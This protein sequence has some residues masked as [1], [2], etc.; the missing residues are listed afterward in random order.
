MEGSEITKIITGED[1]L[2]GA[3]LANDG[4]QRAPLVNAWRSD[5]PDV[6]ALLDDQSVSSRQLVQR[7][8][9]CRKRGTR[10]GHQSGMDRDSPALVLDLDLGKIK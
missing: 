1:H 7:C 5:L 3:G 2:P 10:I 6:L 9:E 4:S 8:R